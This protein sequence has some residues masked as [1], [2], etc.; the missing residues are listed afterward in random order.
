METKKGQIQVS[1]ENIFPIIRQWLYS[2]RDIFLR[3]LISNAAD[4][5]SKL[6]QLSHM[7]E[8]ELSEEEELRIEIRLN[9]NEGKLMILDNGIGMTSEEVDKYINQIAYSGM[10]DFVTQYQKHGAEDAGFIGHFGLGFYSAFMVA[11]SVVIDSLSWQ[12]TAKPVKWHSEEGI[13]YQMSA[14][15]KASRGT[16]ITLTLTAEDKSWLTV[17]KL[18][19]IIDKYGRFL[20]WPIYFT[21]VDETNAEAL[22]T[23]DMSTDKPTPGEAVNIVDPLWLEVPSQVTDQEYIDFY[24]ETF[25]SVQVPL[26]WVH[27][28]MDYPFRLKG[29]LYF[30]QVGNRFQTL[31]GRILVFYNQV[32]VSD[33]VKEIIPEY[34]FLLQGVLDC[35][36]LPLN[37]SRSFLQNDPNMRRL[38]QHIVRKVADRLNKLFKEDREYYEQVWPKISVF[39]KYGILSD[40]KFYDSVKSSLI[41]ATT[42]NKYISE[43]ELGEGKV[44]YT[45]A[46]DQLALYTRLATEQG[47]PVLIMDQEIDVP[48]M[49]FLEYHGSGQRRFVRVD[50]DFSATEDKELSKLIKL[51]PLAGELKISGIKIASLGEEAPPAV[52]HEAEEKR[53]IREISQQMGLEQQMADEIKEKLETVE[54]DLVLNEDSRLTSRFLR[55]A[56]LPDREDTAKTLAAYIFDLTKLAQG[57]L[58]GNELADFI[59]KSARLAEQALSE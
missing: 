16:S 4:A 48:L 3:E 23:V 26:F 54:I 2:D 31:G 37:V 27:L 18:K 35:P 50:S 15:Q 21:K 6:R 53:R 52:L 33:N 59:D 36:D 22:S 45:P 12:E 5:L 38:S 20:A 51:F 10:N 47:Q 29:I 56:E 14:S 32:F 44:L 25:H 49:S 40:P 58:S 9:E 39:V 8:L 13:D 57:V 55:I 17:D 34:L 28:N 19:Q 24:K 1:T 30:P 7:G 41:F 11:D 46:A 43:Q 42:D